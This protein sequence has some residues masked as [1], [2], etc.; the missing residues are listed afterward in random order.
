MTKYSPLTDDLESRGSET[1]HY[2]FGQL[3]DIVGGLPSSAR[4][5]R[6]W[7]SNEGGSR[8]H[9]QSQAWMNA[10]YVVEIVD[11]AR[12]MVGFRRV[13]PARG[14]L[15]LAF[16]VR[17]DS[18]N[19]PPK[20]V[21]HISKELVDRLAAGIRGDERSLAELPLLEVEVSIRAGD[22]WQHEH[23]DTRFGVV[24]H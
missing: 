17:Y 15:I 11:L 4:R 7:W 21:L 20:G 5:H 1:I 22:E 18:P 6:A 24:L 14:A 23:W 3:D 12:E 9:V 19:A 8:S 10:G 2:R 16:Y 13:S